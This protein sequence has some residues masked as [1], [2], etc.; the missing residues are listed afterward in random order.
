MRYSE[1]LSKE[2]CSKLFCGVGL[3]SDNLPIPGLSISNS[4]ETFLV[5][6]SYD[7]DSFISKAKSLSIA[8][9][10]IRVQFCPNSLQNISQNIHL[11]S[12]IPERL[13]SGKIKYHQIPIH[14]IP[15]F[16][17]G[18]ILSTLHIPVYVF[19][20]GLYQQSPA[21]N[22]YI[23]NHTLQQWMDIGFLPAVHTHYTDD[24]L[25][26]L[27]T[28]FDSAYM[29]VYAR[30]RESGIKRSSNDPQLGRRQEIHY[31]LPLE[32]LENVW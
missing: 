18:T 5:N 9:K 11:F 14:H 22:S 2:L 21:P 27:P 13:I 20:P 24:I 4:S 7:I 8:K 25:Q 1:N 16:R 32:H 12:P 6:C 23:N 15:H 10:G 26:H 31:F 19:L 17:L 30:S 3:Q 28:S 29:E